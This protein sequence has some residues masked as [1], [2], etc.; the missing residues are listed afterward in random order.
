MERLHIAATHP[1]HCTPHARMRNRAS[2][3]AP[4]WRDEQP[5]R[6]PIPL[7]LFAWLMAWAGGVAGLVRF[8]KNE[9]KAAAHA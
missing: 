3:S 9:K 8:F 4:Q 2:L 6:I 7:N 1:L 5:S